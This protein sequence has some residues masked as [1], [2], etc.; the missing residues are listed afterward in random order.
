MP[1]T[2]WLDGTTGGLSVNGWWC[3][4][5]HMEGEELE[6]SWVHLTGEESFRSQ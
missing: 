4:A 1:V 2:A 5:F 6:D 3:V